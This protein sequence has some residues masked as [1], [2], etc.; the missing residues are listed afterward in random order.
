MHWTWTGIFLIK[1]DSSLWISTRY[2]IKSN[3]WSPLPRATP[4]CCTAEPITCKTK[5]P[6]SCMESESLGVGLPMGDKWCWEPGKPLLWGSFCGTSISS[7]LPQLPL[8]SRDQ[9]KAPLLYQVSWASVT[10]ITL[11]AIPGLNPHCPS[12]MKD[13]ALRTWADPL[14]FCPPRIL[15][16]TQQK[17]NKW[18]LLMIKIT[19]LQ[20]NLKG[21][22]CLH[23]ISGWEEIIVRI[24]MNQWHW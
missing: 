4:V 6:S 20:R 1:F 18:L 12:Q 8:V 3:Q 17:C 24:T 16:P 10:H 11:S 21:Q 9:I 13:T 7:L 15:P 22:R 19:S 2:L 23:Y 5:I 14:A